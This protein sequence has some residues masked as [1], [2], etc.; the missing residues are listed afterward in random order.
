MLRGAWRRSDDLEYSPLL[1]HS[2][3]GP[4]PAILEADSRARNEILNRLGHEHALGFRQFRHP[5]G[6]VHSDPFHA[7]IDQ[8]AFT[9]VN[10][11][12]DV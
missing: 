10:T 6:Y 8:F 5:C 4:Q 2:L 3:H 9:G 12:A 7:A 1:R 11:D